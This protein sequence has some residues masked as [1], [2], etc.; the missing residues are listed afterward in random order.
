MTFSGYYNSSWTGLNATLSGFAEDQYINGRLG[1]T[2]N[3][4]GS[5]ELF[6]PVG[7]QTAYVPFNFEVSH[8]NTSGII[9]VGI[10]PDQGNTKSVIELYSMMGE[11][12]LFINL[13]GEIQFDLN[14]SHLPA[15][16]YV[17]RL[18]D[19]ERNAHQKII[20]D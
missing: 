16:V 20:K 15:G 12:L 8:A 19:G 4:E 3:N 13:A 1:F 9:T 18:I 6:Y 17:I 5:L 11:R 2:L 14:L 7:T 10:T